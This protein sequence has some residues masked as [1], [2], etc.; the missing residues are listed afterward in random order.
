M[1]FGWFG[2]ILYIWRFFLLF[3]RKV[4]TFVWINHN[5]T[6]ILMDKNLCLI[7]WN[8]FQLVWCK[9]YTFD[10]FQFKSKA[11]FQ[12]WGHSVLKGLSASWDD[13]PQ[14]LLGCWLSPNTLV[15]KFMTKDHIIYIVLLFMIHLCFFFRPLNSTFGITWWIGTCWVPCWRSFPTN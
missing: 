14:D 15:S 5:F 1:G 9:F 13:V 7:L 6:S 8:G 11:L 3:F 10:S 2:H 12:E 4:Q